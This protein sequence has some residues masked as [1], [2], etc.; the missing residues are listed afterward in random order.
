MKLLL[1]QAWNLP[2][3]NMLGGDFKDKLSTFAA[4]PLHSDV[5][6][7]VSGVYYV[8]LHYMALVTS[9]SVIS[10]FK[11]PKVEKIEQ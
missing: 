6:S 10:E 1:K 9:C 7:Q 4:R 2:L 8:L 3:L 5:G 11:V